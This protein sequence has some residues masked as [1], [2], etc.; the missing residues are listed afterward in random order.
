MAAVERFGEQIAPGGGRAVHDAGER[1]VGQGT[2]L[3]GALA[4]L[5]LAGPDTR[6]ATAPQNDQEAQQQRGEDGEVQP[7]RKPLQ[8]PAQGQGHPEQE[9]SQ[10]GPE[11]GRQGLGD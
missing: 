9:I 1:P 4:H 10:A 5:G 2:G 8:D 7:S 3:F 6:L 11:G